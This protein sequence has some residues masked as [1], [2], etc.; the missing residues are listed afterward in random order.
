[1]LH[2]GH[3]SLIAVSIGN[4]LVLWHTREE[5]DA[6]MHGVEREATEGMQAD[7]DAFLGQER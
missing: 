6:F 1:M 4:G 5:W 2:I 7:L 3:S